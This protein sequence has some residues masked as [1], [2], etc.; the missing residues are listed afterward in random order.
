MNQRFHLL[1]RGILIENNKI[2]LAKSVY[3][4][5]YFLPGGHHEVGETLVSTLKREFLEE[6]NTE[7]NVK[8]YLGVVEHKWISAETTEYEINHV[9]LI[10]RNIVNI[11][12]ISQEENL[13]FEWKDITQL[14]KINIQ[15]TPL[16]NLLNDIII[17]NENYNSFYSVSF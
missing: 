5:F 14:S 15:P 4:D 9:Y 8:K 3:S 11:E 10:D 7:I 13:I 2:L 1:V 6:T 16:N 17:Q 12:I